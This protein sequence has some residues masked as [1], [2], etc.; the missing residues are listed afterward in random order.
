MGLSH[1]VPLVDS[2]L[3]IEPTG[4]GEGNIRAARRRSRNGLREHGGKSAQCTVC[5]REPQPREGC[6]ELDLRGRATSGARG[7]HSQR[8]RDADWGEEGVPLFLGDKVQQAEAEAVEGRHGAESCGR[9]GKESGIFRTVWREFVTAPTGV[10]K[11][12]LSGAT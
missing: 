2:G 6:F 5:G 4:V 11:V 1:L 12:N 10:G 7:G 9:R 3:G 8:C